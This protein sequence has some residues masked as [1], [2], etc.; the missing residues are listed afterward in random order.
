MHGSLD[1]SH[2][3]GLLGGGLGWQGMGFNNNDS[4]LLGLR[5]F[6]KYELASCFHMPPALIGD[7]EHPVDEFTFITFAMYCMLPIL[8][9]WE[10]ELNLKMFTRKEQFTYYAEFNQEAMLR[11]DRKTS[12][13]SLQTELRNGVISINEWRK[14][15]NLP[16][17]EGGD[18]PLIMASQIAK[19]D[20]VLSGKAN[21]K[22]TTQ[23]ET[24][25]QQNRIN[26]II[27]DYTKLSRQ[28]RQKVY[29]SIVSLNGIVPVTL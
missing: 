18:T 28:D 11:A 19:L 20:D 13:E 21:L 10:A 16:P 1:Q 23:K 7:V 26:R 24:P 5:Q 8:K 9:R 2:R 27:T 14:L 22:T 12:S 6:Q 3:V 29:D 15:K 25:A 17:I 4:Q